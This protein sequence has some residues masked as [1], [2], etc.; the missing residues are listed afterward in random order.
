MF[1]RKK[2]MLIGAAIA[3]ATGMLVSSARAATPTNVRVFD[4]VNNDLISG[5]GNQID[6]FQQATGNGATVSIKP[7]NRDIAF[8]GEPTAIV[9]GDHYIVQA[10]QSANNPARPQLVFDYQF[11]PGTGVGSGQNYV[12]Q[13]DIDYDPAIGAS[14]FATVKLP[15]HGAVGSAWDSTDGYFLNGQT[16]SNTSPTAH[17]WNDG[18]VAYVVSN[19]SNL[20]FL[21]QSGSQAAIDHPYNSSASGEYELRITAFAEDGVTQLASATAFAVVPEPATVGVLGLLGCGALA[22]RRRARA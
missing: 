17:A 6:N 10:G 14:D 13:L 5:N 20:S 3:A 4:S 1:S 21:P 11:D 2:C 15:I 18:S 7:R 19:T 12:L 16:N 9:G 22:R 8:G